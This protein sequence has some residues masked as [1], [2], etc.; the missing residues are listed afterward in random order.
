[1]FVVT[2]QAEQVFNSFEKISAFQ[3]VV[4]RKEQRDTMTFRIEL[5]DEGIDK[6]RLAD[7]LN[8]KFQDVCRVKADKIDF[9]AKGTI[10]AEHKT[11]VDERTWR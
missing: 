4:G 1:M 10:P 6:G 5:K 7:D 3:I 9:V 2:K 11:I 8:S